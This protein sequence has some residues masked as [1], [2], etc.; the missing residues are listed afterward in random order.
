MKKLSTDNPF[1]DLMG[2]IGD[3]IILNILF[4]ITSIPVI[5]A[6][7]SLTALYQVT[8][9]RQRGESN[10]VARE[11]IKAFREEWKQS[12]VLWLAF[13]LTGALLLFDIFY[14]RNLGKEM[15]IAI[16]CLIV[17]WSFVFSYTFPLQAR[18]QNT[19]K[20]TYKNALFL[21]V[22]HFPYTILIV[23]L[24]SIPVICIAAGA[25]ITMMAL[26][27]YCFVGFALTV[28]INSIFFDK[29]FQA[30]MSKSEGTREYEN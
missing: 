30:F 17:V 12:T 13:L 7:A 1:F 22:R 20:N 18:F 21:S 27:I 24:N 26:P 14:V 25:F 28:K 15:A 9:R 16:G 2:N 29:I 8:L 11:Y 3:L 10:Y 6:G 19:I 4:V 5:T 23:G